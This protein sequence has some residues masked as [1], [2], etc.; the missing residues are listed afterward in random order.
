MATVGFETDP[1]PGAEEVEQ[2]AQGTRSAVA[3]RATFSTDT[4]QAALTLD[5]YERSMCAIRQHLLG[6]HFCRRSCLIT[7]PRFLRMG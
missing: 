1:F 5:I 2:I 7:T 6:E 4:L 3:M